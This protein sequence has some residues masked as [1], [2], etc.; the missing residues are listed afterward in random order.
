MVNNRIKI[1]RTVK[2]LTQKEMAEQLHK[3]QST[4]SRMESGELTI[5][6]DELKDIATVLGCS[7]EDLLKEQGVINVLQN[8]EK[9]TV[10]GNYNE[11]DPNVFAAYHK[12]M[13]QLMADHQQRAQEQMLLMMKE[14][15]MAIKKD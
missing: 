11:N 3:S 1:L 4:Y 8:N 10:T 12:E 7:A 14:I 6:T 9:F 5:S 2:G 13:L 15:I